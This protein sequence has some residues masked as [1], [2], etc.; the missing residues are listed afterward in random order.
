MPAS[1]SSTYAASMEMVAPWSFVI[2]GN[3]V[4]QPFHDRI[5]STRADIFL[6]L[7]DGKRYLNQPSH[8][9]GLEVDIDALG[10]EQGLVL[11][12]QAGVGRGENLLEVGSGERRELD[13]DRKASLQFGIRSDGLAK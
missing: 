5:K 10:G 1:R 2:E 7:V 8:A 11:P 9:L 4:E 12:R 13:A 6:P 3:V